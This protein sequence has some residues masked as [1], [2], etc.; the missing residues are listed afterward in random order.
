MASTIGLHAYPC[1]RKGKVD[2][3]VQLREVLDLEGYIMTQNMGLTPGNYTNTISRV[4]IQRLQPH[5]H[6]QIL[7]PDN[8]G[9]GAL[10]T[11]FCRQGNPALI[12]RCQ[13]SSDISHAITFAREHDL[14]ISIRSGAHH[15]ASFATNDGGLI[16][17]LS[18]MRSITFDPKQ[19]IA[20]IETGATW[21]EVAGTL[22]PYNLALTSGDTSS[23]GVGG[24]A[25]NGGIGWMVRKYGLT[26]D[27]LH[28]VNLVTADGHYLR[29]SA[30]ENADLFWG[31]HGGGGNFG[32]AT[33]IE[34]RPHPGGTVLFGSIYYDARGAFDILRRWA[35]YSSEA[36]EG[37]TVQAFILSP[38]RQVPALVQILL[39][40]TGDLDEGAKAIE[41]LRHL[42]TPLFEEIKPMP[43]AEVVPPSGMAQFLSAEFFLRGSFMET[44]SDEA[45][46]AMLVGYGRPGAPPLQLR[47]LGGAMSRVP[48][49]ATAFAYRDRQ[50]M[51]HSWI[52]AFPSTAERVRK[53][54]DDCWQPLLPFESGVYSGFH[55]GKSKESILKAF[56]PA[57]YERLLALKNRYDPTNVFYNNHNIRPSQ[58]PPH[59]DRVT[60]EAETK[61]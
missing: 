28:A 21:G 1:V 4:A 6:G 32:V 36:P 46:R 51:L 31:L 57:T 29:A 15:P 30:E 47:V 19:G 45:I 14:E 35:Q 13:D 54:M 5:L 49:D 17:D 40:Y 48:A 58:Q 42:E 25:L 3:T 11:V 10:S 60:S 37:L 8:P 44:L 55:Q 59:T 33:S 50:I 38:D 34:F 16:I 39:C 23:V 26:I 56:P 27:H 43:Y 52:G 9:Y 41:P 61:D 2:T 18:P 53:I 12:V 24:L 7:L 22:Q 20:S